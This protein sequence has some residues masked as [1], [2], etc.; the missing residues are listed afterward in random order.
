M[1]TPSTSGSVGWRGLRGD[2]AG[3]RPGRVVGLVGVEQ[4]QAQAEEQ[5]GH[6]D[7]QQDG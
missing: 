4:R 2:G 7:Q 1:N 6:A 3:P 5:E